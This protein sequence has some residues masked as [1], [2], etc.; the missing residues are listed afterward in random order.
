MV[1]NKHQSLLEAIV[2][3]WWRPASHRAVLSNIS[4]CQKEFWSFWRWPPSPWYWS[5]QDRWWSMVTMGTR[6]MFGKPGTDFFFF[7]PDPQN[8]LSKHLQDRHRTLWKVRRNSVRYISPCCWPCCATCIYTWWCCD[9][10]VV[11]VVFAVNGPKQLVIGSFNIHGSRNKLERGETSSWLMEHDIV[12]LCE[13]MTR[14]MIDA[15]G[16][17][18]FIGN[19]STTTIL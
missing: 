4:W 15:P 16:F 19:N 10:Q 2:L 12:F 7:N 18:V 14:N 1:L 8:A 9:R 17:T 3:Y 5:P 13:S 6:R 11:P